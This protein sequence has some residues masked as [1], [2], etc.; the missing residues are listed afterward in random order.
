M[1]NSWGT[2]WGESGYMRVLIQEG[3]GI[4]NIQKEPVY[5]ILAD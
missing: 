4:A 3:I 5:P 1:K 2:S